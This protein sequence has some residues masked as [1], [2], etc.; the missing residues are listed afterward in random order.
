MGASLYKAVEAASVLESRFGVSAEVFDLRFIVPLDLEP[1]VESVKKTGRLL[2]VSEAVERGSYLHTIA[3]K[4]QDLAFE[5]L[6][7]PVV[8]I[9]SRNWIT[10]AAE[11]ESLFFPQVCWILVAVHSASSIDW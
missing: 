10:P 3:S 1:I 11:M 7:A 6:D 8:V 9:G 5:Y 4:V 2:L